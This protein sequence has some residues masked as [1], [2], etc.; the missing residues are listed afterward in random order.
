MMLGKI[1][2]QRFLRGVVTLASASVV[3]QLIMLAAMPFLTRLYTPES[4]GV[5]AVFSA[6]MGVVLVI[7]SWRYEL[8]IPLLPGH[9]NAS[10]LLLLAL[11]INFL[12]AS[13][14]AVVVLMFRFEIAGWADTPLLA[15]FL[16]LLPVAILTGGTYK[17][18]NYWSIRS[19]D[20]RKIAITKITQSSVNVLVQLLGGIVGIG[21][22]GLVIGQIIGQS[23]GVTRLWKG[24]KFKRMR[25]EVSK[26][27][28]FALLSRYRNFPKYDAPAATLNASSAQLPNIAMAFIFGPA[29]AGMYY[30]ADRVLSVPMSIV[31]QAIGQV[32]FSRI[33]D[34]IANE[35]LFKRVIGI[36]LP[37]ILL[38]I[39]LCFLVFFFAESLFSLVFGEKW[40]VA[41]GF[42]SW[43]IVGLSVQ[44]LYS[45][46]S[47]VLM[48]TNGQLVN[49]IINFI[50]LILKCLALYFGMIE[51]E[52]LYAVKL[53][54]VSLILGYGVGVAIIIYR[55]CSSKH[56]KGFKR[57]GCR[58]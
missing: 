48:A 16:W 50:I 24:L 49:L 2:E 29:A 36:L 3:G 32:L 9:K 54:T 18:L 43:L 15:S 21:A 55:I 56:M 33:R 28:S 53:I 44:F 19:K 22:I 4:F 31:S 47:M 20:Y 42:A 1:K 17:A 34:D 30:L 40:R 14:S 46:L 12:S 58:L 35:F 51:D 10:R 52:Q 8:A 7:S 13:I 6:I 26:K 27:H 57:G 39:F 23:A 38:L 5:F 37:L 25:A 11:I 41:G 45:P